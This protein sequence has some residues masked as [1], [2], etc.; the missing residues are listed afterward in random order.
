LCKRGLQHRGCSLAFVSKVR[1]NSIHRS[2]CSSQEKNTSLSAAM[3]FSVVTTVIMEHVF[4]GGGTSAAAGPPGFDVSFSGAMSGVEGRV[5]AVYTAIANG[6]DGGDDDMVAGCR[7]AMEIMKGSPIARRDV[8]I[9]VLRHN[10]L[11]PG[12][13]WVRPDDRVP[14]T[15]DEA[16]MRALFTTAIAAMLLFDNIHPSG[17]TA[18]FDIADAADVA[19]A[20]DA[21]TTP[22]VSPAP[23]RPTFG[24]AGWYKAV[25]RVG[26]PEQIARVQP[27]AVSHIEEMCRVM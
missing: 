13:G 15:K 12:E 9:T 7:R 21:A 18:L 20:Y 24:D 25:I 17:I 6:A 16:R 3:E 11:D 8:A 22:S 10:I 19:A 4:V 27:G 26:T 2:C 23:P 1:R 5:L 14:T